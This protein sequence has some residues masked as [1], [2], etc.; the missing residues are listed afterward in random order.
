MHGE[1]KGWEGPFTLFYRNDCLLV[2]LNDEGR[3]H[4]FHFKM[5]QAYR[6]WNMKIKDLINPTDTKTLNTM[7]TMPTELAH[8]ENDMIY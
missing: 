6:Q 3:E 7:Y 5:L 4:L 8:N 1:K 2:V